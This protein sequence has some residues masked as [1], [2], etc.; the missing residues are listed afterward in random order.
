MVK[1]VVFKPPENALQKTIESLNKA[2]A[3]TK[4]AESIIQSG[5]DA[6]RVLSNA[7]D[8]CEAAWDAAWHALNAEERRQRRNTHYIIG[9]SP[10]TNP[11]AP[12]PAGDG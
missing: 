8:T 5:G 1:R 3:L 9:C 6:A 12:A 2:L 7:H 11:A 4:Q 10:L